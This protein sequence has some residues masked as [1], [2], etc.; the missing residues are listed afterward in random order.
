MFDSLDLEI[1][2]ALQK[3]AR[4]S[5]SDIAK[6]LGVSPSI[7]QIRFNK[8]KKAG[9]IKGTTLVL[10]LSKIGIEHLV[11][12]GVKA[13][14]P[15]L[16]EVTKYISDLKIEESQIFAWHTFGRYNIVAV[17]ISRNLLAAHKIRQLIKEHPYVIEVSISI[18]NFSYF[19]DE[20]LG[21]EKAFER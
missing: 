17:I 12:I 6:M 21:L 1:I 14:E 2:H 18:N 15:R 19:S 9:L 20:A 16:E 7:I 4:T 13:L 11:S 8:M 5:F 10:D 3:D